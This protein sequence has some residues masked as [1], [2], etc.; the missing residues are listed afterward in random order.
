MG[1]H[2]SNCKLIKINDIK[3]VTYTD[4]GCVNWCRLFEEPFSRD[5]STV[6]S[7]P[8]YASPHFPSSS[9]HRQ[10]IETD[11]DNWCSLDQSPRGSGVMAIRP[12]AV[13]YKTYFKPWTHPWAS[14][15]SGPC[16]GPKGWSWALPEQA[17]SLTS[18][19]YGQSSSGLRNTSF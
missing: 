13:F 12:I 8:Y 4:V 11:W 9:C 3:R 10:E 7:W 2:Y 15:R 18:K 16:E 6:I 17:S 14:S 19:N 5:W 1:L